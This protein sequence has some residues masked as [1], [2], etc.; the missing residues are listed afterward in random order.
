MDRAADLDDGA[1]RQRRAGVISWS[2]SAIDE[3][4]PQVVRHENTSLP[5]QMIADL[6]AWLTELAG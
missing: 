4:G 2:T 1:E 6:E 3:L 5:T